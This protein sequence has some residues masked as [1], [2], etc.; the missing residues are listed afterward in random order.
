M[1]NKDEM[2]WRI[3]EKGFRK[4]LTG[5]G[6]PDDN[7]EIKILKSI[8]FFNRK[9][10]RQSVSDLFKE[11][12]DIPNAEVQFSE[13]L[14]ST[15]N[16]SNFSLI[17][18]NEPRIRGAFPS[19]CLKN[20]KI[21]DGLLAN[22]SDV[23]L[24]LYKY[25]F[26]KIVQYIIKNSGS[27]EQAKDIFQDEL[28]IILEKI[29]LKSFEITCDFG[30]YL[31]SI[32]RNLWFSQLKKQK[33]EIISIPDNFFDDVRYDIDYIDSDN[34]P[35]DYDIMEQAISK[36]GEGCQQLLNLFYYEQRGWKTIADNL[37]YTSAANARNQKYKCLE[38]IRNMII[39]SNKSEAVDTVQKNM[40]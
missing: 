2:N 36:L 17:L 1:N 4:W 25:E 3:P 14:T 21:I 28:I 9:K 6:K 23:Y 24:I 26:P 7:T 29:N 19:Y 13:I 39:G 40:H 33:K 12:F 34:M 32:C 22:D 35:D 5:V 10:I 30:T 15:H 38:K 37:G 8:Y 20:E 16:Q 11:R 31:Y 18:S 27:I